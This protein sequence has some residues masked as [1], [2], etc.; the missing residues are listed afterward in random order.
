M[1]KVLGAMAH[2]SLAVV[3]DQL[4]HVPRHVCPELRACVLARPRAGLPP[5]GGLHHWQHL[6][7][8][9][10]W[11]PKA[12]SRPLSRSTPSASL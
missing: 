8:T 6:Q 10:R 4:L 3:L 9:V 7:E 12:A 11:G 1:L 2:S 5:R